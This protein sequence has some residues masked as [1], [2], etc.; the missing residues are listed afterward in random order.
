VFQGKFKAEDFEWKERGDARAN[1]VTG[2]E[3]SHCGVSGTVPSPYYAHQACNSSNFAP[4][5]PK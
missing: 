2:L 4:T 3:T 1:L 5:L